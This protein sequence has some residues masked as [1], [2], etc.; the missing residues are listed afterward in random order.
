MNEE[1]IA[2]MMK[3][4]MGGMLITHYVLVCEVVTSDGMDLRIATS[5][6]MTPWHA[7]GMLQVAGDMLATGVPC[8]DDDEDDDE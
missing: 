8:D 5:D 3:D 2:A 6:S 1:Q 7:T 4:A